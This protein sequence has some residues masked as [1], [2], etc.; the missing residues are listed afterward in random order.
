[1]KMQWTSMAVAA[2]LAGAGCAVA[3]VYVRRALRR[4]AERRQTTD[5]Q[6]RELAAAVKAL[7]SRVAELSRRP[8]A[9]N[10]E[11]ITAAA[12]GASETTLEQPKPEMLAV[13]TAAATAFLGK[14]ARIRSTKLVSV[15]AENASPWSQ[16]G[17][18]IVQTSHNLRT[19]E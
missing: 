6:M 15:A 14:T 12:E 10:I 13:M 11:S 3:C 7:E 5:S 4:A 8:H 17:R 2:L 16:Q 19:R 18:V 9:N 1:M